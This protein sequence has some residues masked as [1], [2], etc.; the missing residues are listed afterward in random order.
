MAA[1]GDYKGYTYLVLT[2]AQVDALDAAAPTPGGMEISRVIDQA[3]SVTASDIVDESV[4]S[5]QLADTTIKYAE[6]ALTKANILAM[7]T[8]PVEVLAAPGA[9][10]ALEFVSSVV[11]FDYDTA[12]YGGGGDVTFKYDSA[13]TVSSTISAANSFGASADKVT[14]CNALDTANGIALSANTAIQITNATGVFTDPGTAAGVARL[15]IA[16]RVHATGL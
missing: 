10:Y 6:V 3:A 4:G 8:T 12:A 11:I 14:L 2:E 15:K 5:E 1:A 7:Y 16:Y 13:A 9:G